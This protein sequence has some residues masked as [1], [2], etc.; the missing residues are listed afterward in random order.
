MKFHAPFVYKAEVSFDDPNRSDDNLFGRKSTK[1]K[2]LMSAVEIEMQSLNDD[3]APIVALINETHW[4]KED[5]SF[6]IRHFD[7]EFFFAPR[8]RMT[9]SSISEC[10]LLHLFMP[11]DTNDFLSTQYAEVFNKWKLLKDRN[12]ETVLGLSPGEEIVTGTI[13]SRKQYHADQ[14]IKKLGQYALID[15]ELW[16]RIEEPKISTSLNLSRYPIQK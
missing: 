5:S 12:S 13:S 15:G 10:D 3:E 8:E 4:N 14:L 11:I 7:G 16:T 1:T 6:A 9:L 2:L